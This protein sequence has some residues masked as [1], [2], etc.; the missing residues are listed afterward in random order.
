MVVQCKLNLILDLDNTLVESFLAS[1]VPK[2]LLDSSLE[3]V[4]VD[5]NEPESGTVKYTIFARPHLQTFLDFVFEHFN[6]GIITHSLPTY[7]RTIVSYFVKPDATTRKVVFL[8]D[9]HYVRNKSFVTNS[10]YGTKPLAYFFDHHIYKYKFFPCNTI[11]IDD[12]MDVLSTNYFNTLHIPAFKLVD[13]FM[14]VRTSSLEDSS[15]LLM[16][17]ALSNI[18]QTYPLKCEKVSNVAQCMNEVN[19]PIFETYDRFVKMSDDDV[20]QLLRF[21]S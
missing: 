14:H 3:R 8:F 13:G 4:T 18:V 1:S 9:R 11:L 2:L 10:Y 15:L 19:K 6:V 5:I 12:N 20:K 17:K 16:T 21:L 7:A